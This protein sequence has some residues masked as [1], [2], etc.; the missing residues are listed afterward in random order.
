MSDEQSGY[1]LAFPFSVPEDA[2][3]HGYIFAAGPF[4]WPYFFG[5]LGRTKTSAPEMA[6]LMFAEWP[7]SWT[8]AAAQIPKSDLE[9]LHARRFNT[10]HRLALGV[11]AFS[12][13]REGSDPPDITATGT[14]QGKLGIDCT[15]LTVP[16]RREVH[17]L[18]HA[19]R[20]R[21]LDRDPS[22]FPNLA[23]HI[24]FI[25]FSTNNPSPT[26]RPFRRSDNDAI[27]D[28]MTKLAAYKPPPAKVWRP[29]E[30]AEPLKPF[31]PERTAY[32]ADFYAFPIRPNAP[33]S[34]FFTLT[35]FEL[36]LNYSSFLTTTAV[37]TEIQRLAD[38]HDQPGVDVL[39]ITAGAPDRNGDIF[40]SEAAL[41][42]FIA[43]SKLGLGKQPKHIKWVWL[44]SWATGR[45]TMLY[46]NRIN[47]FGPMYTSLLPAHHPLASYVEAMQRQAEQAAG[48]PNPGQQ[49]PSR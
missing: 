6:L 30:P 22:E 10:D 31:T 13:V 39:L 8:W 14:E 34:R 46:P 36:A 24:V 3:L 25:S 43:E 48:S 23:R 35:G 5:G 20:Q 12:D 38:K 11:H 16:G 47:L 41:A 4:A 49:K 2:D 17:G 1:G 26:I 7:Y 32:G 29:N 9:L 37:T 18:F 19:F 44:H 33:A 40:P 15:A 21:M 27:T 42:Q 28:L 45:A